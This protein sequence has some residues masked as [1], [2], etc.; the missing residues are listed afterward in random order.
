M[1][2]H[3]V[4]SI[5]SQQRWYTISWAKSEGKARKDSKSPPCHQVLPCRLQ[6]PRAQPEPLDTG[7]KASAPFVLGW[8]I[9]RKMLLSQE[10]D[11]F[12]L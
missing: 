7:Y 5:Q 2:F 1:L 11:F 6:Y 12:S 10:P 3:L 8:L 9:P 4:P